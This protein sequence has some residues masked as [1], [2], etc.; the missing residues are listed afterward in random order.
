MQEITPII[1]F[2]SESVANWS[3]NNN[4]TGTKRV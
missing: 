4:V 3:P 1:R 2:N